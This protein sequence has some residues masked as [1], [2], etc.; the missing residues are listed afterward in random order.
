MISLRTYIYQQTMPSQKG[1]P[2]IR[3]HKGSEYIKSSSQNT[4]KKVSLIRIKDEIKF[5]YID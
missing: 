3:Q 1:N 2:K 4:G 5:L